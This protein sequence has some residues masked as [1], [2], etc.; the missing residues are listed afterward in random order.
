[1]SLG[2]LGSIVNMVGDRGPKR[3]SESV[4]WDALDALPHSLVALHTTALSLDAVP[5]QA[6]Q[7]WRGSSEAAVVVGRTFNLDRFETGG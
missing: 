5:V 7:T 6:P 3:A 4:V 2:S 1:M